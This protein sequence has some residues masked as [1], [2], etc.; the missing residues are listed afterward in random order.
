MFRKFAM[1]FYQQPDRNH[2]AMFT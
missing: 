1:M 2:S